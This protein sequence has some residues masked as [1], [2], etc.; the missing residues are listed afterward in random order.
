MPSFD[1][2]NKPEH[3]ANGKVECIDAIEAATQSL[4]GFEAFCTGQV[5]KY[6]WRWKMKGG[7]QDLEKAR[8][9]IDR[10]LK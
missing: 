7:R 9:Y 10:L 5:I 6:T 4:Q 2:V 3:Y 8:W 1:P